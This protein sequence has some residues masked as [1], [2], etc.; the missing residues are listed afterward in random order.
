MVLI[1][2][3]LLSLLHLPKKI[4]MAIGTQ[5]YAI[6]VVTF[7]CSRGS[8]YTFSDIHASELQT[9][10]PCNS[11]LTLLHPTPFRYIVKTFLSDSSL[12]AGISISTF[13][14]SQ[15]NKTSYLLLIQYVLR[16]SESSVRSFDI[17]FSL[18]K[19]AQLVWLTTRAGLTSFLTSTNDV[20]YSINIP[21]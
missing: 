2:L 18:A 13:E 3:F 11:V 6:D 14:A 4:D 5:P 15:Q 9:H 21:T 1:T 19:E 7:A 17:C 12:Q 20:P 10:L 8:S 16:N